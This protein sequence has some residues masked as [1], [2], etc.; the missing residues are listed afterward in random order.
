MSMY[1]GDYADDETVYF[2]WDSFA[3]AGASITRATNGTISVYRDDNATQTTTGV[4]DSEDFDALTGIH[5]VTIATTDAFYQTGADY[6]VVLSAATIDGQ[7]VNAVLATF[8]I[9][10]RYNDVNVASIAAN[11]ITAAAIATGAITAAKFAAG[12]IDAAAV[13]TGAIDADAMAANSIDASALAT[14]AVTEIVTA[15]LAGV[16]ETSPSTGLGDAMAYILAATAGRSSGQNTTSPVFASQGNTTRVSGTTDANNN[17]TA[18][19][20]TAPV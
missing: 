7:T 3:A 19:T 5:H 4:T 13:G 14:D 2:K 11:A 9:Q 17:R 20:Y 10:N 12:A 6:S 8:S 1:L 18:I 16:V 15:V